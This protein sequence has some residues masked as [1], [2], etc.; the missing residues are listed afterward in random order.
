MA[1]M[2]LTRAPSVS[3]ARCELT[4]LERTPIDVARARAQHLAYERCLA[5]LGCTLLRLPEEPDLPDA[6]FVEDAAVVL[7]ELAVIT[8]PGAPSRRAELDAVATALA[9]H[10]TRFTIE[11]PGTLDGGDVLVAGRRVFAGLT[12]RTNA[13]GVD[14]LRL[15]LGPL[16]YDVVAVRV[17]GCLHLKTAVTE[18]APGVVLLNPAWIDCSAFAAFEQIEVHPEEP[19]AANALRVGPALVY[20]A[21]HER[22]RARLEARGLDVRL[23]PADELAKAEGGV[24][25]CSLIFEVPA[26]ASGGAGRDRRRRTAPRG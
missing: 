1:L 20:P 10:R 7:D 21:A 24:T 14:Q 5:R 2:A 13:A 25:C 19:F 22:T 17:D 23:V 8:R 4:H 11:A 3:L 18:V 9:P 12:A 26:K 6:V 16:G 15:A